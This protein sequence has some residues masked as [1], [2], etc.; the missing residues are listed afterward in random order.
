[1]DIHRHNTMQDHDLHRNTLIPISE[2]LAKSSG[3]RPGC[4]PESPANPPVR[5]SS[6]GTPFLATPLSS[7]KSIGLLGSPRTSAPMRPH[8]DP[9]MAIA[10]TD[11]PE[12]ATLPDCLRDH[13]PALRSNW[14]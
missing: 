5:R 14:I 7:P 4:F 2:N 6:T 11:I 1:M 3:N 8:G 12:A 13:L 10:L 9:L